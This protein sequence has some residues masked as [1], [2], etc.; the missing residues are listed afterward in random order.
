MA[1]TT[2]PAARLRARHLL[3]IQPDAHGV[4]AGAE[5]LHLPGARN[6][7]EHV[8][9]LQPGVVAQV[10]HVIAVVR[11]DQVH[12]HGD[13][14]GALDRGDPLLAD[15]FGQAGQRLAD[16]VLHL[17]L[18]QVHVRP[19]PEGDGQGQHAV[20]RRLRRHVQHVVDAVDLLLQRRGHGLGQHP[21]VGP[22]IHRLHHDGRRHHVRVLADRQ[23]EHRDDAAE[24]D[25]DR[26]HRRE[27]RAV[28][29]E[30]GKAHGGCLPE[31]FSVSAARPASGPR[32]P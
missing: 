29:E 30:S 16:P 31:P 28:D 17:H 14:G 8:L 1:A 22:G 23:A 32:W 15:L 13:V 20:G 11:R 27:D 19:H 25:D 10:D 24:E 3:R 6:A 12:H 9:D 7:P 21:G 4:V 26:Q 18:G 2:S 5:E